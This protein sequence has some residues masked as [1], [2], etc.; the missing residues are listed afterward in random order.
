MTRTS[1]KACGIRR[2]PRC[3]ASQWRSNR[4]EWL[5]FGAFVAPNLVL[6]VT[7]TY[8]PIVYSLHLS[9]LEWDLIE[10]SA[11]WAGLGNY[12][13]ILNNPQVWRVASNTLIYAASVVIVAQ[14]L[15]FFL[16]LLLNLKLR[17]QTIFR[18]LAFTPYI[19]TTA[20][21]A[22]VWVL[23]L[24]SK[25]G[26]FS[27]IFARLGVEGP[28]WLARSGLA[29]VAIILVGIWR[30]IAFATVFFVAGLQGL[31]PECYEA[32][33][34]DGATRRTMLWRLTVPLMSPV[35]FFLN[36]SGFI[37]A[38]KMF[39][40]VAI[41][42]KGGPVYPASST[43]VYHLYKLAFRDFEAGAASAFAVLFL[44][45]ILVATIAQFRAGQKW[46]HYE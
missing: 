14:F 36:V 30:E 19:A 46:V 16:A 22:L 33:A 39:D 44:M 8:W 25:L 18:T 37:A 32:A 27:F 15:A 13:R 45:V 1:L 24:D 2:R 35:I 7:F 4:S 38:I 5:T 17:G 41:M 23:L 3:I 12:A 42:T 26:P 29:L 10:P 9:F 31:P 11:V 20:A 40:I 21:A 6:F 28:Q 34:L 43:Y